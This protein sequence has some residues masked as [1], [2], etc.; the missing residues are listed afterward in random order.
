MT[1]NLIL[2]SL[3]EIIRG[4][5]TRRE[6]CTVRDIVQYLSEYWAGVIVFFFKTSIDPAG[7]TEK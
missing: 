4:N 2:L 1:N 6:N 5:V 3:K 7:P